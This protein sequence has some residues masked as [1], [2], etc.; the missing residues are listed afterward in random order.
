VS[1]ALFAPLF[2]RGYEHL[3]E[4]AELLDARLYR[5]W[6]ATLDPAI[7]YSAYAHLVRM[8]GE[9]VPL[10]PPLFLE[11]HASLRT[12]CEQLTTP[13]LSVSDNPPAPTRH[14]VTNVRLRTSDAPDT[15]RV[16][17]Y[18]LV[19][20]TRGTDLPPF[21]LSALREDEFTVTPDALRLRRRRVRCDDAVITSRSLSFF[22]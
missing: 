14:F 15:C 18:V 22:L 1:D 2:E 4:E 17:S 12:R 13:G 5:Q 9:E 21:F 19:Y 11:N 20:R 16:D 3:M 8:Q 10:G 6:H 7:H